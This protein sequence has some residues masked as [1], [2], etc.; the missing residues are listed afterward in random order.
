MIPDVLVRPGAVLGILGGG[1]LGRM[2]ALAARPL[3]YRVHVLDPDPHC[4]A[5]PVVGRG[6]DVVT[7][8]IETVS[9][10]ALEACDLEA[11]LRPSAAV[12]T[13]VQDRVFQKRWLEMRDF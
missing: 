11:P 4:A 3:G 2:I 1:Q 9:T 10:A 7:L 12:V 8:E 13:T 6:A 5:S